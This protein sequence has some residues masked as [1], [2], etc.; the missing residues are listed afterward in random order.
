[1][2]S[3]IQSPLSNIYANGQLMLTV[4]YERWD[5][6]YELPNSSK[7]YFGTNGRFSHN[8]RNGSWSLDKCTVNVFDHPAQHTPVVTEDAQ[9]KP[10][11]ARINQR[12]KV[13]EN[14]WEQD[15]ELFLPG[16]SEDEDRVW[17]IQQILEDFKTCSLSLYY[18]SP[19]V[20]TWARSAYSIKHARFLAAI[21]SWVADID[22][23]AYDE[24]QFELMATKLR[25]NAFEKNVVL[26][27]DSGLVDL[28][29]IYLQ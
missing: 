7:I 17:T 22:L 20:F 26:A 8:P 16:W 6:C 9:A 15:D 19:T 14:E 27:S 29:L 21:C 24:E 18:E 3:K 4:S 13:F 11:A 23:T 25:S 12:L 5:H 28:G 2:A 1:M 10:L